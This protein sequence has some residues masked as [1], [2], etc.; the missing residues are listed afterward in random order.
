MVMS[1]SNGFQAEA[2]A[3]LDL[4]DALLLSAVCKVNFEVEPHCTKCFDGPDISVL[5]MDLRLSK[6][7]R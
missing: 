5:F 3:T 7:T 6:T 2:N 4:V 1:A